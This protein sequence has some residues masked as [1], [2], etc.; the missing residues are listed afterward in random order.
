[1]PVS[2]RYLVRYLKWCLLMKKNQWSIYKMWW[3]LLCKV[4][5][6]FVMSFVRMENEWE[7]HETKMLNIKFEVKAQLPSLPVYPLGCAVFDNLCSLNCLK[8]MK[9]KIWKWI[10]IVK[11]D[12]SPSP[13]YWKKDC[14]QSSSSGS[15]SSSSSLSGSATSEFFICR[16]RASD[17]LINLFSGGR[18]RF[19]Q[20]KNGTTQNAAKGQSKTEPSSSDIM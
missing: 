1:M 9:V 2:L 6:I 4:F 11:F 10:E 19:L 5:P 15:T 7:Y 12:R 17:M 16:R 20:A 14:P 13:P 8:N 3:M 18:S